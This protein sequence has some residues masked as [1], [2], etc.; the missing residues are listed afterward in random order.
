M[1]EILS[2]I[3]QIIADDDAAGVPRRAVI[4]AAGDPMQAT[5]ARP[6]DRDLSDMLDDIEPLT[7][8]TS[9]IVDSS[10]DDIDGFSFYSILADTPVEDDEPAAVAPPL[11]DPEDVSFAPAVPE[12]DDDLPSFG[13]PV[14]RAI[15]P[16]PTPVAAKAKPAL[17]L[18]PEPVVADID[19]D[20]P[21]FDLNL[22]W[23]S[24]RSIPSR[25]LRPKPSR[26]M[27]L[28]PK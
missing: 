7:L 10:D 23:I 18:E 6:A 16:D 22:T 13:P 12:E 3:R 17:A 20:I 9:Q 11:V 28:S 8:S 5:P 14:Q 21:Q 27:I 26:R 1:D 19:L 15:V 4:Q 25:W 2:S 24:P